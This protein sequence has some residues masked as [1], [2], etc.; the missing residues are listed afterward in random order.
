MANDPFGIN[1]PVR[2]PESKARLQR[3]QNIYNA[4]AVGSPFGATREKPWSNAGELIETEPGVFRLANATRFTPA[5]GATPSLGQGRLRQPFEE[6]FATS[7]AGPLFS[8]AEGVFHP[9][10]FLPTW[11]S[12][13]YKQKALAESLPRPNL[14][15]GQVFQEYKPETLRK[16]EY[17]TDLQKQ[18]PDLYEPEEIPVPDFVAPQP[19]TT[20][21][22]RQQITGA[23]TPATPQAQTVPAT[24]VA[25]QQQAA[26]LA[27]PSGGPKFAGDRWLPSRQTAFQS[28]PQLLESVTQ[29]IIN[30]VRQG[31]PPQ[32]NQP[33][34]GTT[35][36]SQLPPLNVGGGPTRNVQKTVINGV[37]YQYD[38]ATKSWVQ[39]EGLPS[40]EAKT[41]ADNVLITVPFYLREAYGIN[42]AKLPKS[43]VDSYESKYKLDQQEELKRQDLAYKQEVL[44]VQKA[45]DVV[46]SANKAADNARQ[47]QLADAQIKALKDNAD[48][49]EKELAVEIAKLTDI[50]NARNQSVAWQQ[51]LQKYKAEQDRQARLDQQKQAFMDYM[52]KS[53][54]LGM[55]AGQAAAKAQA[56]RFQQ[57]ES[58]LAR[59]LREREMALVEAQTPFRGLRSQQSVRTSPFYQR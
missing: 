24:A 14:P 28:E 21:Q 13:Y 31:N 29:D 32:G 17:F 52:L 48:R 40:V 4:S 51:Y 55:Q 11:Y 34:Q 43:V 46:E 18:Y 7:N 2:S 53:Q 54:S 26:P 22:V 27:Q 58:A 36:A 49:A 56:L 57:E 6:P 3:A 8:P 16:P 30:Q 44:A 42:Q 25:G 9:Q 50:I 12:N 45:R 41:A 19:L 37:T 20:E 23:T 39:A 1:N 10:E 35:G 5:G 59:A 47:Q 38:P 15:A 33:L